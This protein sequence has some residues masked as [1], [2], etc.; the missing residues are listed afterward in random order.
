VGVTLSSA[1]ANSVTH[2]TIGAPKSHLSG[3]QNVFSSKD[4]YLLRRKE[5]KNC[6]C[7]QPA[8]AQGV[9][10]PDCWDKRTD[11]VVIDGCYLFTQIEASD[12]NQENRFPVERSSLAAN[13][14][15]EK[16]Q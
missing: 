8:L 10:C 13:N 15:R 5:M 6:A 11:K 4:S 1:K 3:P 7:G 9:E 14:Q 12:E 16:S 2:K